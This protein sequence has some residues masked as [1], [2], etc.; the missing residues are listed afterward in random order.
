MIK[1]IPHTKQLKTELGRYIQRV[2]SDQTLKKNLVWE[3]R[4]TIEFNV[5][6]R[7]DDHKSWSHNSNLT[8]SKGTGVELDIRRN[9]TTAIVPGLSSRRAKRISVGTGNVSKLDRQD[10]IFRL[11]NPRRHIDDKRVRL[12]RILQSGARPHVIMARH[13]QVHLLNFYWKRVGRRV[14][15]LSVKHPGIR[16]RKYWYVADMENGGVSLYKSD[17]EIMDRV[18]NAFADYL[19]RAT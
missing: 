15:R 17:Y 13:P 19:R 16:P 14:K 12:W 18:K 5:K 3:Q 4:R 1:F 2:Y 7:F 9:I 6:K 10:P 8:D 11:K